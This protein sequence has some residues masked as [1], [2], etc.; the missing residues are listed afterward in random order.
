[1]QKE[2]KE[3]EENEKKYYKLA[4]YFVTVG[5][6]DYYTQDEYYSTR[7]EP[8]PQ[9][10]SRQSISQINS[11]LDHDDP[12]K[13]IVSRPSDTIFAQSIPDFNIIDN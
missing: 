8:Q 9:D 3:I 2:Q 12:S 7:K 5:I 13:S 10:A 4:D 6:D 11:F 1:M